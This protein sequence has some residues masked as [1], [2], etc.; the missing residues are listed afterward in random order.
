MPKDNKELR[1]ALSLV[2]GP[3]QDATPPSLRGCSPPVVTPASPSPARSRPPVRLLPDV[4]RRSLLQ[5]NGC[6]WKGGRLRVE[7]AKDP[8]TTK[9]R[10]EEAALA[11]ARAAKV[12]AAAAAPLAAAE[13]RPRLELS[14]LKLHIE[15]REPGGR[16][17]PA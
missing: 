9:L 7:V 12:A 14:Q 3:L 4:A 10:K 5:Y 1:R 15:G 6:L 11:A 13:A 16:V 8:I 17:R 2:R